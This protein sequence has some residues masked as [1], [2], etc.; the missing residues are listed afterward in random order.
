MDENLD[1]RRETADTD[2]SSDRSPQLLARGKHDFPSSRPDASDPVRP[3]PL[4]V[5]ELPNDPEARAELEAGMQLLGF[6]LDEIYDHQ[7]MVADMLAA[8]REDGRPLYRKNAVAIPRRGMKTTTLWAIAIGRCL[9]P[10]RR[11]GRNGYQVVFTSSSGIEASKRILEDVIDPLEAL[12]DTS[13]PATPFKLYKSNGKEYVYFKDT[14]ARI[15]V[16]K[17]AASAFRGSSVDFAMV[18]E[19]QLLE[20][21]AVEHLMAGIIPTFGTRPQAQLVVTGTSTLQVGLLWDTLED[22]RDPETRTAGIVE[23]AAHPETPDFDPEVME[24][25]EGTT[26]D[27]AVWIAAHPGIPLTPVDFIADQFE[28]LAL[29]AFRNEYLGLFDSGAARRFFPEDIW[30]QASAGPGLP[31][32]ADLPANWQVSFAVHP[33]RLWSAVAV[34][35]RDD[36][37][38]GH[39]MVLDARKGDDWLAPFLIEFG[40]KYR[41]KTIWLNRKLESNRAVH[42]ELNKAVPRIKTAEV[43]ASDVQ[44]S[45][46]VLYRDLMRGNLRHYD[47]P[48]MNRAA[49]NVVKKEWDGGRWWFFRNTFDADITGVEAAALALFQADRAPKPRTIPRMTLQ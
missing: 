48:D 38:L 6:P 36:D 30:L 21:E 2:Q 17:P 23:F 14:G 25:V 45:H 16:V 27:P 15:R 39:V 43:Q 1:E 10:K 46:T 20:P 13:D 37:G 40:H 41:S 47:Q 24:S 5:S 29:R 11:N 49:E 33:D 22:G 18:D 7:Y 12:W 31:N 34:S 8:K 9:N 35:W 42:E 19:A 44:T 32:I 4:H 3:L 26:A 28:S